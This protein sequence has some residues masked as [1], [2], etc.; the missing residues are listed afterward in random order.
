MLTLAGEGSDYSDHQPSDVSPL[1]RMLQ[2]GY[3]DLTT[4]T[5][6]REPHKLISADRHR[7][8][9][10]SLGWLSLDSQLR[11]HR[12]P[13]SIVICFLTLSLVAF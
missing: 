8:G 3:R 11:G 9:G 10:P 2:L 7:P 5:G 12:M 4:G 1:V 6:Q 13:E